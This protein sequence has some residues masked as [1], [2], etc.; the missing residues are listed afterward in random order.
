MNTADFASVFDTIWSPPGFLYAV[1]YSLTTAVMLSHEKSVGGLKRKRLSGLA[2]WLFLSGL[3]ELTSGSD[4]LVYILSM[5]TV[6]SVIALC[7]QFNVK[8]WTRAL[9]LAVKTFL[10]SEFASSF[11]W[12][13]YHL[14]ALYHTQ[15]RSVLWLN[16]FMFGGFL[17]IMSGFWFIERAVRRGGVV[18]SYSWRDVA[19]AFLIGLITYTISNLGYVSRG[20]LFSGTQARDIFAM[21]TLSDMSGVCMIVLMQFQ[22]RE[23]QTRFETNSLRGIMQ[24]QYQTYQ[25]SQESIEL[26]HRKYHDLKHQ[27]AVLREQA[28]SPKTEARLEQMEQ[29]IRSFEAMHRTGNGVLDAVLTNKSLYCQKHGIELKFIADGS[30]LS[31][32]DEM[33]IAALF[34]NML[35]NAIESVEQLEDPAQRLIR[36][37]VA[38]ENGFLRIR[39]E[40]TCGEKL[41]F[42]DGLPLTTKDDARYHG[43]GMKSML[44]TVEKYGGSLVAGQEDNWFS[45]KILIP[46]QS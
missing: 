33:E 37:Y 1:G 5:L 29:E 18:F 4:G 30:A 15:F 34:G 35:D 28:A 27:I 11:C 43:F 20:T 21:H 7:F 38:S 12:Q 3:M 13:I 41:R 45:L 31:M 36:L 39:M 44:R 2:V 42:E 46:I 19:V 32:L 40:N 10:G 17:L 8:D 26:V 9:F 24:L 14:T 25:A 22:L 16:G 6:F 23:L